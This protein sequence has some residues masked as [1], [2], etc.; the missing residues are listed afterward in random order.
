VANGSCGSVTLGPAEIAAVR[1]N[2]SQ[3][4][5]RYIGAVYHPPLC[6]DLEIL[7]E[8][9]LIRKLCAIVR[10]VQPE[11][12]LIPSPQDYMEDHTT[13]SRLMVTAAFC[14]NIPNYAADP[15]TPAVN[16]EM[17]VYHAMPIGL[18]D[19][20]RN[21]IVP[22]SYVDVA[23]V[24]DRKREMLACHKSQKE[25][26]DETQGHD[27]Y[28]NLMQQM[29]AEVG[30]LSGRFEFAEGWRIHSHLG[31]GSPNFDPLAAALSDR[32]MKGQW[33]GGA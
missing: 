24:I 23:S 1:T 32:L 17:A 19:Q 8:Q 16:N 30:K 13:T 25:W 33:K 4:A 22:D 15:P 5:A 3:E 29:A 18:C 9:S 10:R 7:Y 20:L 11:I 14:R 2:E 12:L 28:L 26:L 27:N 31:F 21:P 6:W